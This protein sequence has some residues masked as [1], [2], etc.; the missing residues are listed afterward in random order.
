MTQIS[1]GDRVRILSTSATESLGIAGLVGDVLGQT[2]PSASGVSE[3]IG[4]LT[5]DYAINVSFDDR[6]ESY[7]LTEDLLEFVDHGAGAEIRLDGIPKKWVRT[8]SGEWLEI[9]LAESQDNKPWWERIYG[10]V[11]GRRRGL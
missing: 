10:W 1:F 11:L 5:K 7:W 9:D 8:S 2:I 6:Q 4:D 3:I